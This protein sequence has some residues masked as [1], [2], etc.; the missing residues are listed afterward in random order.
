MVSP[1][2]LFVGCEPLS[3][4]DEICHEKYCRRLQ[5]NG[6]FNVSLESGMLHV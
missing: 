6:E 2:L 3:K 5:K 4:C 1:F